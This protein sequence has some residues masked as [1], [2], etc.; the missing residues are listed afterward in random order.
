[1]IKGILKP[2]LEEALTE[3]YAEGYK[4]GAE[5]VAHRMAFIYDACRELGKADGYAEAGAIKI[6]DISA[7]EFEEVC[8][9][10]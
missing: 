1:M 4:Q 6:E 9:D 10:A 3:A 2:I 7:E 8:G 5:D